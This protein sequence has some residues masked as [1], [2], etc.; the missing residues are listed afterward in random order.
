M[1]AAF[2]LVY[3]FKPMHRYCER[4]EKVTVDGN[5]WCQDVDCPAEEGYPLLTYGDYLADLKVTRLIRVW[6]TASLYAA[7][8]DSEPVLLKVA[9]PTDE[10]SERLRREATA[11]EVMSPRTSG[12]RAFVRSFF[13]TPRPLYPVLMPA[14]LGGSSRPFGEV[15][16]RGQPRVFCVYQYAEG[17]ILS[18]LMLENPQ[19]WHTQSAWI[20]ETIGRAFQ[21]L[22]SNNKIHLCLSP[23]IVLVDEDRH[24]NLRPMLLDLGLLVDGAE[25]SEIQGWV[26]MC[27]PAYT[28]PEVLAGST[29]GGPTLS[30]DSYSLGLIYYEMLA[31]RPAYE[32]KLLRDEQLW[33]DVIESRKPPPVGRPELEMSGVAAILERAVAPANR[34]ENTVEFSGAL[35]EVYS[36]PPR[37][38]RPV[39]RR[40]YA[41]I[42][43]IGLVLLAVGVF[44]GLTLLQVITAP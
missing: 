25:V 2:G 28:A 12:M 44:A 20:V 22:V 9:H 14:Y 16:F 30:A 40:F 3:N 23:D 27:E 8:R 42:A 41:L 6:R 36:S 34:Y 17:K 24:G 39:P 19:I 4:C 33:E 15:S 10:C 1:T 11:L 35:T 21:P 43:V 7:Q 32:T 13:P 37:E 31:G 18:D 26:K 29:N 38:R 5:L